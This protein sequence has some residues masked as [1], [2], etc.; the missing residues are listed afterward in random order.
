MSY[1]T[2][3]ERQV[4]YLLIFVIF[5]GSVGKYC[6][7]RYPFLKD[8]VN[9]I[10]SNF[11]ASKIDINTADF[12]ELEAIPYIGEYTARNIIE[13][14]SV[15]GSFRT[16]DDIKKVRGIRDKNFERFALYLKVRNSD[17]K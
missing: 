16:V 5:S 3:Q 15:N 4:L 10:E 8:A 6:L 7:K 14:R 1:F 11:F 12:D 13:Y 2:T 9:G 17:A